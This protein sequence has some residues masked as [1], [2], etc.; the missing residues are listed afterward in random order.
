MKIYIVT[1]IKSGQEKMFPFHRVGCGRD[2]GNELPLPQT[3]E[4]A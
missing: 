4:S 1:K 3:G 2:V